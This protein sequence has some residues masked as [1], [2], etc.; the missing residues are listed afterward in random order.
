MDASPCLVQFFSSDAHGTDSLGLAGR[1]FGLSVHHFIL[2]SLVGVDDVLSLNLVA[3]VVDVRQILAIFTNTGLSIS[4]HERLVQFIL[5]VEGSTESVLL[6]LT[7]RY[8]RIVIRVLTGLCGGIGEKAS[9][10]AHSGLASIS[11]SV[12]HERSFIAFEEGVHGLLLLV[13]NAPIL[14]LTV[15]LV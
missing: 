3:T 1:I 4:V 6:G 8:S 9:A 10:F 14:T 12:R 15:F 7:D 11:T 5:N 2:C 13:E